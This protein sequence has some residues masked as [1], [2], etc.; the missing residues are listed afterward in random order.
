[1][2]RR[3]LLILVLAS[4]AVGCAA[5]RAFRQGDEAARL[6]DWDTAV[7]HYRRAVQ[8]A[9]DR[10]DYKIQLERAMQNAALTH[11]AAAYDL[12]AKDQLDLALKEY[13]KALEYDLSNR[14]ASAKAAELERK[15]RDRVEAARPKPKIDELR[16]KARQ[17]GQ[18]PI[19]NPA[20]REPLK[21]VFNNASVRDILNSM[22]STAGINV[23]YDQQAES[24]VNR[25][26]TVNLEGVTLEEALNQVLTANGLFYKVVNPRTIIVIPDIPAKR[27][28]YEEL[29]IKTFF[30]SHADA[31]ELTTMINQV[32]RLPG[33]QPAVMAN[34]TANTITIRTTAAL[35]AVIERVIRANDKPRAE[36]LLDVE[37]LE[38]NRTRLKEYGLNLSNYSVNLFFSPEQPPSTAGGVTSTPPFNL[39][40][41]TQGIST[42]DF[43]LAV[44]T[45]VV[46]FLETDSNTRILAKPQLRGAEGQKLTLNLGQQVPVLSTVFGAAAAGGFAT[47]PQS[48]FNYRDVGVNLEMEPRVSYEGEIILTLGIEVSALGPNIEVAGQNV[49]SFQTRRVSTRLRLREGE[50]NLLAGLI[51]QNERKS[52]S[53]F[54]GLIRVPVFKQLFSG[55]RNESEENDIVMLITPHI[56]RTHELTAEDLAPIFIGTQGNI[57]L[58]GPPPLIAPQ[59][60]PEEP[61]SRI[62]PGPGVTQQPGTRLGVPVGPEAGATPGGVPQTSRPGVPP[63]T[64]PTPGQLPPVA[65]VAPPGA[66]P[67]TPAVPPPGTEQPPPVAPPVPSRERPPPT[68]P[69]TPEAPAPAPSAAAQVIVTPPGTEFRVA[70]GPYTVPISING[71]ARA[72]TATITL[73]FN[74]ST[75]RARNAQEG[76]FMRQ[77]G[78]ATSFTPRVDAVSGRVDIVI[79]RLSD[80]TGASGSGLL[81]AVIFDA[82]APG[83]TT[84]TVSGLATTPEGGTIPLQFSPVT[85]TIR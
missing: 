69:A 80:A 47:I 19:L 5:G 61:E 70:G 60:I 39:N 56:V 44:P 16:E 78:V 36:I 28:Q 63:G 1:M 22:G 12:E 85:V 57:G 21:V 46:R 40:T 64:A 18:E 52:I 8:E 29:V 48:S 42:A 26:F 75:V 4:T 83:S 33:S 66:A 37:I 30:L 15:I 49:P 54:P 3:V 32:A 27:A 35:A 20:R 84:F 65:P 79:T 7:I 38:V 2:T 76:S 13:R 34:K 82:I 17:L 62:D 14:I 51:Q 58:G 25:G 68:A 81:A 74:S 55:N 72:S 6:G 41:I 24:A 73:T 59:P 77:G 71:V 31:T 45:A 50:S 9:P 43:Y 10:P 67:A 23:I 11:L 53:G